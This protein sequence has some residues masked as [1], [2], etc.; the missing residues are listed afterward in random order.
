MTQ[1]PFDAEDQWAEDGYIVLR[2]LLPLTRLAELKQRIAARIIGDPVPNLAGD[3]D[4]AILNSFRRDT[5]CHQL[6]F[7]ELGPSAFEI[8]FCQPVIAIA[9]R[10]LGAEV[11][12]NPTQHVRVKLPTRLY[13][14]TVG[15]ADPDVVPWHQDAF[16]KD[17]APHLCDM[18]TF[19]VPLVS[20]HRVNGTIA[21]F[22]GSH[23]EGPIKHDRTGIVCGLPAGRPRW[24]TAEPGD[25][26]VFH[27]HLVHGSTAN[28]SLSLRWSIDFRVQAKG[29]FSGRDD[30]PN[31]P[32]PTE[33]PYCRTS[34]L[35]SW[36][37]QQ[38]AACG[39]LEGSK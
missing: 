38:R 30:A 24:I 10:L 3:V 39:L 33:E 31:I 27:K 14:E 7:Y 19:W 26:V 9:T 34:L 32:L 1:F 22:P 4:A 36:L 35:L 13:Q 6:S 21:V 37:A 8:I 11:E 20:V 15:R 29:A 16:A 18:V 23:R 25:V 2:G 5:K 17:P 12:L 28:D